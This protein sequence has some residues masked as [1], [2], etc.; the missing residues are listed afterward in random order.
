MPYPTDQFPDLLASVKSLVSSAWKDTEID[1]VKIDRWLEN[2]SGEYADLDIERYHAFH[3]LAQLIYFGKR[4]IDECLRVLFQEKVVYPFVQQQKNLGGNVASIWA[5]L[6]AQLKQRTR[7]VGVGNPSESGPSFLY[8]FRQ[9][10][11]LP[12]EIFSSI[13]E[14]VK[15]GPPLQGSSEPTIDIN[16]STL[17][18][19]IYMDDFCATGQ[20]VACRESKT[21]QRIRSS[22]ADLKIH[23]FILFATNSAIQFLQ[24]TGLF[25][26][27]EAVIVLDDDYKAF[28]S[29]SHFYR[30]TTSGIDMLMAKAIMFH[31]GQKLSSN[32]CHA[33]GYRDSQMLVSFKHNTPDNTLP[34][35]WKAN[36]DIP[37]HPIFA[38]AQKFDN[39]II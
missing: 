12:T 22:K 39:I 6:L 10:N 37:W 26:R 18:E 29:N 3:L 2:F 13:S 31:Y 8:P 21:I 15:L 23:Y 38:R 5:D 20:Q 32:P 9:A 25:N 7:F 28:S 11:G 17:T 1:A 34:V 30:S 19:L 14:T 27:V 35:I 24:S 36:Q 16:P 33:L 4:E